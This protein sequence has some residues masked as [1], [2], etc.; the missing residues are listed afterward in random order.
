MQV[1]SISRAALAVLV[2]GALFCSARPRRNRSAASRGTWNPLR[3]D[4]GRIEALR[5][6]VF[7]GRRVEELK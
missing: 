2:S 4:A 7:A 1:S 3:N 5:G 6:R